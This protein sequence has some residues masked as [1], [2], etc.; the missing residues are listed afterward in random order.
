MHYARARAISS[1][2]LSA[3]IEDLFCLLRVQA[4]QLMKDKPGQGLAIQELPSIGQISHIGHQ[5]G[6]KFHQLFHTLFRYFHNSLLAEENPS[7]GYPF[8]PLGK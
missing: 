5:G 1:H 4:D 6:T 7:P 8:Q 2:G 3:T